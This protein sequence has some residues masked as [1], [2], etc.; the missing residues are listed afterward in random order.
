MVK[1]LVDESTGKLLG[2]LLVDAGYD[3]TFVGDW[4]PGAIDKDVLKKAYTEN[5]III[6]DDK[7]FGELVFRQGQKSKGV[8]LL[9]T[10][11]SNPN[12]RF[13][14][15]NRLIKTVDLSNKF[16]VIRK[17]AIKMVKF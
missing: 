13:S 5:R 7:D 9:R 3:V 11:T 1:F 16:I 10:K 14:I 2:L 17:E 8:I 4:K 6:T 12:V 15:L